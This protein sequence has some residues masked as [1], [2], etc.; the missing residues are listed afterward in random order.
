[1]RQAREALPKRRQVAL[2][3]KF[4]PHTPGGHVFG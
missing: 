4:G 1:M 3:Q 2:I